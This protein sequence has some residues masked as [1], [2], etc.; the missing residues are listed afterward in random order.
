MTI[1]CDVSRLEIHALLII[2]KL[3]LQKLR[4]GKKV[5]K[6]CKLQSIDINSFCE[7]PRNSDLL[8]KSYLHL[9]TLVEQYD[10]TLL[11]ILD[12]H[13]PEIQQQITVRPSAPWYT[14]EVSDEKNKRRRLERKWRTLVHAFVS[15][16]LDYCNTL[17]I[18]LPK[19]QI[20]RL[21]S[22]LKYCGSHYNFY[23]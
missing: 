5:V 3:H 7:D 13:A 10:C 16:K 22:V 8:Q 6:F 4:F 15:S 23:L 21:Q 12:K 2:S 17:L 18:E 14:Q 1:W 19:Y 20:D 9:N 11:S